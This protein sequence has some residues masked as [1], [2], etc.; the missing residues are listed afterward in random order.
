MFHHCFTVFSTTVSPFLIS[1]LCQGQLSVW[2]ICFSSPWVPVTSWLQWVTWVTSAKNWKRTPVSPHL[3]GF[4]NFPRS[5]AG[6]PKYSRDLSSIWLRTISMFSIFASLQVKMPAL[7]FTGAF[8][9]RIFNLLWFPTSIYRIC[10]TLPS[11]W[12]VHITFSL[13]QWFECDSSSTGTS[14]VATVAIFSRRCA[15]VWGVLIRRAT[16]SCKSC[17][18]RAL[19]WRRRWG[20]FTWNLRDFE[21]SKSFKNLNLPHLFFWNGETVKLAPIVKD[22]L[23]VVTWQEWGYR[24]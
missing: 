5:E 4:C 18:S 17:K 12:K 8:K 9:Y 24:I 14:F 11:L 1:W 15:N 22:M 19:P 2:E 3:P 10:K 16:V 20:A 23:G 21:P 13:R 7:L 6:F